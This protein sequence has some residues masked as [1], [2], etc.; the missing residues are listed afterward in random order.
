LS[1]F[2]AVRRPLE[3]RIYRRQGRDETRFQ[4]IFELVLQTY[5][6]PLAD[7]AKA[8]PQFQPGRLKTIRLLFDRTYLGTVVLDDVG[9]SPAM[10]PAF[11]AGELP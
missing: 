5:V 8:A 10:N 6:L 3:T 4:N 7:F 11:R 9:I 2:G 1:R